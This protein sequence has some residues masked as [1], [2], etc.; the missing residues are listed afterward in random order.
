MKS[1]IVQS[2]CLEFLENLPEKSADLVFG[3]PPYENARMC[4]EDG[5]NIGIARPTVEWVVWMSRVYIAALRVS[6]GL[7]AF[8]IEGRTKDFAYSGG[9]LLLGA[10][11]LELG[12]TLRKP[13]IFRRVGIPGSGG[14][15][16]FRNDYEFVLC[17]TNGGKLPWSD[18]TACGHTPK[19]AP[20]GAMSNRQADGVRKNARDQWGGTRKNGKHRRP[21]GTTETYERPRHVFDSA[22]SGKGIEVKLANPGNVVNRMY[23][24]QEVYDILCQYGCESSEII[25]CKVGGGVM[26]SK[27][28]HENEAPFPEELAERYIKSF[29]PPDGI[30]VDPFSG[31][32]TTLAVAERL[33]RKGIGCDLRQSQVDLTNRRL[34]ELSS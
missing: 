24:A 28:C 4:L 23:S 19:Y 20:G 7:V 31:S 8:V 1:V 18:N 33:G 10:K 13:A 16:W 30:V 34:A 26:G 14:P 27:L 5:K 3:S 15:D 22:D 12:V 6:R 29:C 17:A 32:G 11:L 2:D 25:D 9:P 21:D